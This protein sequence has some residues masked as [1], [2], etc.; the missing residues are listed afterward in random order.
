[1]LWRRAARWAVA[2]VL[3]LAVPACGADPAPTRP[4]PPGPETVDVTMREY[5]FD[6]PDIL[7]RGRVV[8]RAR[9]AG[10]VPHDLALV[11]LG[12]DVPPIAEELRNERGRLVRTLASMPPRA[13]GATGTFAVDLAPGRYAVICF[14]ADQDGAQ[15][16]RK[17]M[18]SEFRVAAAPG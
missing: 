8:F 2:G 7:P 17:G 6:L 9:N 11:L 5:H 3:L 15:H 14:V 4:L 18:A 10:R 13:P 16:A 12:E 1:M